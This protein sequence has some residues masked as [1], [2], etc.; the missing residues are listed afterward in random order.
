MFEAVRRALRGSSPTAQPMMSR[1]GIRVEA[2][3]VRSILRA[4]MK[5]QQLIGGK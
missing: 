4:S 1:S 5:D 2:R 3:R